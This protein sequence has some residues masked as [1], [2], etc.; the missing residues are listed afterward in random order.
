[1]RG[2]CV[3]VARHRPRNARSIP[4]HGQWLLLE[5][6]T[7]GRARKVSQARKR[8]ETR[9]RNNGVKVQQQAQAQDRVKRQTT[10][11]THQHDH[12]S[13]QMNHPRPQEPA[14]RLHPCFP[15]TGCSKCAVQSQGWHPE[16]WLQRHHAKRGTRWKSMRRPHGGL[17]TIRLCKPPRRL[18]RR[19]RLRS[20][21]LKSPLAVAGLKLVVCD[22]VCCENCEGMSVITD[23]GSC[24]W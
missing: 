17:R 13:T 1:M 15:F 2:G 23:G 7:S 12:P 16:A 19:L 9:N 10:H 6:E 4:K 11:Q 20:R 22:A 5:R 21:V 24:C 8:N 14:E 3:P 18:G